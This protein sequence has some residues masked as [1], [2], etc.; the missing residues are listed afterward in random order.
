MTITTLDARTAL[1]VLDLQGIVMGID[2]KPFSTAEVLARTRTVAD[3]FRAAGLPVVL[4][5]TTG[6]PQGRT[7]DTPSTSVG[8]PPSPPEGW[9]TLH[10]TLTDQPHHTI[11]KQAW[12]A[13]H[14]GTGLTEL[15]TGLNVTHLVITGIATSL[16]V[17]S[18]ARA[19][20][21]RGY[22]V[23]MITD[24]MTDRDASLHEH[25]T[26]QI[27]PRLGE[28]GTTEE[29]LHQLDSNAPVDGA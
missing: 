28:T 13:F 8:S 16:A 5:R 18:T 20:H 27:F 24:A 2:T 11:S 7:D 1:I 26:T 22:H 12:G 3:A 17:E 15:L 29:L 25:S 14:P 21:E 4:V 9:D 6:A 19:A 10:P 23:T